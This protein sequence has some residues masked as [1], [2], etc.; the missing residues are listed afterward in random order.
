MERVRLGRIPAGLG[1]ADCFVTVESDEKPFLR[2]DLYSS[3]EEAF[4]FE[5]V[6]VWSEFVAIGWGEH[7][8]LRMEGD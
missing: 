8:Y 7:I 1:T 6:Q 5:D 4:A 2:I 3:S